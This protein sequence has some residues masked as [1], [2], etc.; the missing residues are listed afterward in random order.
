VNSLC[1]T[2]IDLCT[3]NRLELVEL[4]DVL[5]RAED[6]VVHLVGVR[7]GEPVGGALD[8][9]NLACLSVAAGSCMVK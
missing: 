2:L 9:H 6:D 4:L 1:A 7:D 8:L 3:K 5:D